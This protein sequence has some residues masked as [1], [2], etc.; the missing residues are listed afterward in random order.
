MSAENTY[1]A[2]VKRIHDAVEF[3]EVDKIPV[4]I[5]G[6]AFV[7]R[8]QGLTL[9]EF[10]FDFDRATQASIDLMAQMETADA[11]QSSIMWPDTLSGL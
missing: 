7:A 6:P 9:K 11:I 1:E 4:S 2:R 3:K 8:S 5:N 10:I